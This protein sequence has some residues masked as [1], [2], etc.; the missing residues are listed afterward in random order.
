M[1]I[2]QLIEQ[3]KELNSSYSLASLLNTTKSR[4]EYNLYKAP[5]SKKYRVFNIPKKRGAPRVISAPIGAIKNYQTTISNILSF[6]Y[7]MTAKST[8]HGFV[9]GK[10]I[11][12]NAKQHVKSRFVLNLDLEDFFPTI[13]FGRVRGMFMKYPFYFNDRIATLIAQMCTNNNQL[14]QGSPTSPIISNFICSKLD[15]EMSKMC[16]SNK[17][18]YTR[19]ADDI[20]VSTSRM[21]LPKAIASYDT[22]DGLKKLTLNNQFEKIITDN[23]F[24]IN[25]SKTRI[26]Q[27]FQHQDVTGI[28]VNSSRPNVNNKLKR[29]VRSMLHAWETYNYAASEFEHFSKYNKKSYNPEHT[30]PSFNKILRGKIEFIGMVKGHQDKVYKKLLVRYRYLTAK[31]PIEINTEISEDIILVGEGKTDWKHLKASLNALNLDN[32]VNS[33]NVHV[34]EVG[35][36]IEMGDSQLLKCCRAW[37]N[38]VNE[39]II[40]C[41]FDGDVPLIVKNATNKELGFKY[42]GNKVYSFILPTPSH[43]TADPELCIEMYYSD[44]EIITTDRSGLR[45]YLNKEFDRKTHTHKIHKNINCTESGKLNR[46]K[47]C[48]IDNNVFEDGNKSIALSKNA[49]ADNVLKGNQ[50]YNSFEFREFLKIYELIGKIKNHASN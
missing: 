16:R 18:I 24:K 44:N 50:G 37:S 21:N 8:S 36:D 48:I 15:S 49:F 9:H 6:Y 17:C 7:L 25:T 28:T 41:M 5:L 34:Q 43:R 13:N 38:R 19:Y 33:L 35:D 3:F 29:S 32:S 14:P 31:P 42:W 39:K 22:C 10:S 46:R 20:S 40:I 2:D 47:L 26:A 4:L 11:V 12:S 27:H 23:G 1:Y 30:K 45:L